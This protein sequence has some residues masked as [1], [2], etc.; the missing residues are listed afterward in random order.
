MKSRRNRQQRRNRRRQKT[1]RKRRL[2]RSLLR[3]LRGGALTSIPT[4]AVVNMRLDPKDPYS[5]PITVGKEQA[6]EI[7]DDASY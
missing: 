7:I 2:S 6:E 3:R 4:G 1:L 5:I